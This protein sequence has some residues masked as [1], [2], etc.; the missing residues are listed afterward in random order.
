MNEQLE[1]IRLS[2]NETDA[3]LTRLLAQRM[4]L[5]AKVAQIKEEAGLPVYDPKREAAVLDKVS[6]LA[7]EEKASYLRRVYQCLM[8]ASKDYERVL[9][10][11]A[12]FPNEEEPPMPDSP[13]VACQGVPGAF[14]GQAAQR[15]FPNGKIV[16]VPTWNDTFQKVASGEC[17]FA[18]LPVENSLAGSVSQVYDLLLKYRFMINRSC[19][20]SVEQNLLTLPEAQLE[21]ITEIYSHP[22]GLAQCK[23]FCDTISIGKCRNNIRSHIGIWIIK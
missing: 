7:G 12:A 1:Q 9:M 2:I 16:Y 19:R 3:Q 20:L 15:M 6:A 10:E 17:D 4:D 5:V 14:S 11:P 8:D 13:K 23:P 18:V 22:Q 21:D